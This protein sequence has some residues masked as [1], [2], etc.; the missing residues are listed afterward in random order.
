MDSI[1][2]DINPLARFISKC[3]TT[4]YPIKRTK[5]ELGSFIDRLS[6][7]EEIS[8]QD[9]FN[10]MNMPEKMANSWFHNETVLELGRVLYSMQIS[11]ISI[12]TM[13]FIR[14]AL[15]SQLRKSSFQRNKEFK[16]WREEEGDRK[17]PKQLIVPFLRKLDENT[18]RPWNSRERQWGRIASQRYWITTLLRRGLYDVKVRGKSIF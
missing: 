8:L 18:R 10:L 7:V 4:R 15:S 11:D 17:V 6:E 12:Q 5:D 9:S 16:L 14:L 13:D 1:G 3:K 2:F